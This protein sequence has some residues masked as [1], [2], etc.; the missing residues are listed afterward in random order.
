MTNLE[1]SIQFFLQMAAILAVCH[2]CAAVFK[3]LGQPKVV[4]EMIAGVILGPSLF[5]LFFPQA[6]TAFFPKESLTI[7]Y[8]VCQVGL[9][10]YMFL[11]GTEFQASLI[12][13][14]LRSAASVSLAG[15][16]LPF[17]LG[18]AVAWSLL[19]GDARFFNVDVSSA[20]AM[21]FLGAS[22]S[23]TAF[24]MLARII[25]E[26]GLSGTSLGTLALAAGSIDDAAAWCVLAVVLASFA[27]DP[28]IAMVAVG[29]G[30]AFALVTLLGVSRLLKPLGRMVERQGSLG[31]GTLTFVLILVMLGA[32]FTDYIRIYAVFGAFIM[33]L[34]IP[35]GTLT[36][37]LQR[38]LEPLTTNFLL[39]LFFVYSGLNTRLGLAL[40]SVG[41]WAI[42]L[43]LLVC[44]VAGKFGGCWA[45]ARLNG[46]PPREAVAIGTL[47]NAR[48]L[49]ELI[50]LNIGLER[51]IIT[52]TLFTM[53]VVMAIV[54]T[55]MASPIFELA[56]GRHNRRPAPLPARASAP[57]LA[58]AE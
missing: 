18:S 58:V 2:V 38:Q 13:S 55:L 27:G 4:S 26:R 11:I 24:P 15:I 45:A 42:T 37:E 35:R 36:T 14:R 17:A 1:L 28:Q 12:R 41:M 46:E 6:Q 29:G 33:G 21:L 9:V 22:M 49:M 8:S 16:L 50:I 56:Y 39:P 34:A 20:E 5:G 44:A 25:Y 43:L 7:I 3:W 51:G 23:I 30:I 48:G 32:W 47:M 52:P 10:L 31:S 54:T 40:G 57:R 53:M 19:A